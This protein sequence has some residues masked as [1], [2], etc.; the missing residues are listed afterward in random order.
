[1]SGGSTTFLCLF[2][3][4]IE[5]RVVSVC[6]SVCS[7]GR[8]CKVK[9]HQLSL[10][11]ARKKERDSGERREVDRE[12]R[13]R[14]REK[15]RSL[16]YRN[17][18][19]TL[20]VDGWAVG[21]GWELGSLCQAEGRV[22]HEHNENLPSLAFRY[23]A[24]EDTGEEGWKTDV[25]P[26]TEGHHRVFRKWEHQPLSS[27]FLCMCFVFCRV[28]SRGYCPSSVY[29]EDFSTCSC[30]I[31]V[32]VCTRSTGMIWDR[33]CFHQRLVWSGCMKPCECLHQPVYFHQSACECPLRLSTCIPAEYWWMTFLS[34]FAFLL[35]WR[36]CV[37]RVRET[38]WASIVYLNSLL[39]SWN[40][41]QNPAAGRALLVS[42]PSNRGAC[43]LSRA[44][45]FCLEVERLR[46]G[47]CWRL[48]LSFS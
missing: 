21:R 22:E 36:A 43:G 7:S 11:W 34:A 9:T 16:A 31:S 32:R 14:E 35:I 6:Y 39:C 44:L 23:R 10:C 48:E 4:L 42:L 28:V 15:L 37:L 24:E 40:D 12:S 29:S 3:S 45:E 27:L 46:R 25:I 26:E 33:A 1:M 38:V 13:E 8:H 2:L 41:P 30:E 5:V 20:A 18:S 19:F 17:R 47:N